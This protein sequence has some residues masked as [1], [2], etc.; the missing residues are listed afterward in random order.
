MPLLIDY[1]IIT[2]RK[3]RQ[4]DKKFIW[5]IHGRAIREIAGRYYT[6]K[7]IRQWLS[8][9]K[10]EFYESIIENH[11]CIVAEYKGAIIGFGHMD[12]AS[13]LIAGIYV[14]PDYLRRGIGTMLLQAL[15]TKA[16]TLGL[17]ALQLCSSL[18]A[19]PFYESAGYKAHMH[20][21]HQ[22]PDGT[23][24]PCIYMIKKLLPSSHD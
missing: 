8:S 2:I 1:S 17:M 10:P 20:M 22:L 21:K 9:L 12:S 6:P 4:Q 23:E 5:T 3:A 19:L 15:E 24:I 7:Q 13:S 16:G 14:S 11:E 18:N